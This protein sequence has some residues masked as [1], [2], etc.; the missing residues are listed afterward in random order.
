M[1]LELEVRQAQAAPADCHTKLV[2][3]E[4][5]SRGMNVRIEIIY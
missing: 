3:T 4:V 2:G 5:G 1:K